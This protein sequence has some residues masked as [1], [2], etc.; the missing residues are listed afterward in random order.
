M[1]QNWHCFKCPIKTLDVSKG[2]SLNPRKLHFL[3]LFF[4][5]TLCLGLTACSVQNLAL[6]KA[7][8]LLSKES[9]SMDEDLELLMHASAYHLKLSESILQ[10]IP[11]HTELAESVT[12]GYTQYAYVFLMNEAD[13]LESD[14][15]RQA[16]QLRARAAKMLWRAKTIGL[17]HLSLQHPKLQ[18]ILQSSNGFQGIKISNQQVGLA[19]WSMTAWAGAI[20]LSKD[21]PEKVADLPAV[22]KLSELA[23]QANP[24]FDNGALASMMGT[25]EL[26]KP[27]GKPESAQKYYDLA[28]QWRG[29]QIAPLV[30]KAENWAV[31]VQNKESFVQLLKDAIEH[32]EKHQDLSNTVMSNRARWLLE[33]IDNYF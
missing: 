31:A 14:N 19:Y 7:G 23:W 20:S 17:H 27:G 5:G 16:S 24:Q 33:N 6:H 11:E 4:T 2:A 15:I 21:S 13:R 1:K 28:I 12:R 18:E 30:S 9:V 8:D 10:E 26:A 25:L 22:I 29:T 3:K 32:S